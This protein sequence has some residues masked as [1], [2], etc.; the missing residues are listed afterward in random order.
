MKFYFYTFRAPNPVPLHRLD[1]VRPA[2][3][4]I[5]IFKQLFCV[6]SDL[7]KPLRKFPSL[8]QRIRSPATAV[9]DLFIRK[10]RLV[11]RVPVDESSFFVNEAFSKKAREEPLFPFIVMRVAG[12]ELS[13][14]VKG[15]PKRLHLRPHVR[16]VLVGPFCR[17]N[18][19][20]NCRIFRR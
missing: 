2:R 8:N 19:S 16:N 20:L 18:V 10:D 17:R 15:K 7:H 4:L 9:N 6:V 3:Q 13:T 1:F 12:F 11:N 5:Q 14:P